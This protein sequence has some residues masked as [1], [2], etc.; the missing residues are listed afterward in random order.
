MI[1]CCQRKYQQNS[2]EVWPNPQELANSQA[3]EKDRS[4][5]DYGC[6]VQ[7]DKAIHSHTSESI[8]KDSSSQ[9]DS[10]PLAQ[11][12]RKEEEIE[13]P[14]RQYRSQ[15]A[16]MAHRSQAKNST[17]FRMPY[18]QTGAPRTP[19]WQNPVIAHNVYNG[20]DNP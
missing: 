1:L 16:Y 19:R 13:E 15:S 20:R 2:E 5:I 8:R 10:L 12:G 11:C 3:G 4:A 17:F 18:T 14:R 9:K 7:T 6:C